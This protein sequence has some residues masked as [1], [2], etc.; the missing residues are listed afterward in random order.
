MHDVMWPAVQEEELRAQLQEIREKE[1]EKSSDIP[2]L[3]L[4]RE[5]CRCEFMRACAR[6]VWVYLY[7][8]A[9]II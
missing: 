8:R 5:E 1:A 4:E 9:C 2:A 6:K 7:A 3:I